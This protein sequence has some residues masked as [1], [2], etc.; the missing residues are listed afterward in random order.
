MT[1]EEF[2]HIERMDKHELSELRIRS[3]GWVLDNYRIGKIRK[4]TITNLIERANL[5][6]LLDTLIEEERYEYCAI[7]R[8]MLIEVYN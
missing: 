8:D 1:P 4:K 3:L 5:E 6:D 7:I 2:F